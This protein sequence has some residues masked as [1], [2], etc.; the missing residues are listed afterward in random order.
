MR[1][2]TGALISVLIVA[3]AFGF[4]SDKA[5]PRVIVPASFFVRGAIAFNFQYIDNPKDWHAYILCVTMIV[6]S[7]I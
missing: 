3:P 1:V 2:V 5:D 6:I 7:V 4:I